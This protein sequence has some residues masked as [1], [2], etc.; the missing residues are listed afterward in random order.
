M[1]VDFSIKN[2]VCGTNV[3]CTNEFSKSGMSTLKWSF[4]S[5]EQLVI[6]ND[7]IYVPEQF[8][9]D[10]QEELAFACYIGAKKKFD[11]KLNISFFEDEKLCCEFDVFAGFTGW[12]YIKILFS[13]MK[14]FFS[15]KMNRIVITAH[16][17]GELFWDEMMTNYLDLR[18]VSPSYQLPYLPGSNYPDER[19]VSVGSRPWDLSKGIR[20]HRS[21][22][23]T[24]QPV[25]FCDDE[26]KKR[27]CAYL[28]EEFGTV[29][30]Q[31]IREEFLSLQIQK[32]SDG[33]FTGVRV[34]ETFLTRIWKNTPLQ[35]T[36][37]V[38]LRKC[39]DLSFNLA[40]A[41]QNT[42][43]IWYRDAYV[44]LLSYL[45]QSGV[46]EGSILA[47]RHAIDYS[48][49]PL[50]RSFVLM[51]DELGAYGLKEEVR[52][53]CEWFC[54]M[55]RL[56][57]YEGQE[58]WYSTADDFNNMAIG[59]VAVALYTEDP[60]ERSRWFFALKDWLDRNM[61]YSPGLLGIYKEDGSIF[62]HCGHYLGYGMPALAGV[63]PIIWALSDTPYAVS[64]ESWEHTK[65]VLHKLRFS[66]ATGENHDIPIAFSG[67]NVEG[68]WGVSQIPFKYFAR[69][70]K[71]YQDE[72]ISEHL[73]GNVAM[74][75]ACAMLHRRDSQLVLVKGFS[76]YLWGNESYS[77]CNLYGRYSSYGTLEILGN[78]LKESGYVH[79]GFDFRR[80]SGTT[81]IVPP[82]S[83]FKQNIRHVDKDSGYE[84][85]L[86]SDQAFAGG[87]SDGTNGMFSM[88]LTEHPKYNGSHFAIK[89]TFFVDDFVL[90]IGSNI[91]NNS[92]YPTETTL[93]QNATDG[94][95]Y[96]NDFTDISGNIY[97]VKDGQETYVTTG[98]QQSESATGTGPTQGVF[99][100][101]GIL[102]G[103]SPKNATYE[104][105][106]G[107]HGARC[108]QYQIIKQDDVAHIAIIDGITF[109]AIY[110][111]EKFG[112]FGQILSVDLPVLLMIGADGSI[113]IC[114]PDLGL[115]EYDETQYGENGDRMEV[116]IYS[117]TWLGNEIAEKPC[118]L[119]TVNQTYTLSLRGG[120]T[121]VL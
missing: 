1:I 44:S 28:L 81:A 56:G 40:V 72:P 37:F 94:R 55:E 62:H 18:H 73:S 46:Y 60:S 10:F 101:A 67:R 50:Y 29:N 33:F 6:Q 108:K 58:H 70:A 100:R 97:Y 15:R 110:Q 59:F 34:E 89:S 3:S 106:I 30:E 111:P 43:D 102:H 26:I 77:M 93:F 11:G 90:Q 74:N 48:L 32:E 13:Q 98:L 68:I 12:R 120:T 88:I 103:I 79:E 35:G 23:S 17:D 9:A 104:Y 41:Y 5:G 63:L 54:D 113:H 20:K 2:N 80:F 52:N 53:L 82:M 117:R 16:C 114:N 4:H 25:S 64:K 42:K 121:Y 47:S 69:A 65:N 49:R 75:L 118:I 87:V 95:E 76:K 83:E 7:G 14:G 61:Q 24:F 36:P 96:P 21:L 86:L 116:S 107:L 66:C 19:F 31:A 92:P 119:E 45:M 8:Q 51:T 38:S 115:Y 22:K 112:G 71:Y 99:K 109:M 84:E 78:S 27:L 85:M 57:V 105:A 91:T 39:T